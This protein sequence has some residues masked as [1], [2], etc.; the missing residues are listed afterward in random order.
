MGCS[1]FLV[2]D[3]TTPAIGEGDLLAIC[4]GSGETKSM[5]VYADTAIKC[6][7]K[8]LLFTTKDSSSLAEKADSIVVIHGKAAKNKEDGKQLSAQPLSNLFAQA[9]GLTMDMLVI[10][11]MNKRNIDEDHMKAYH[12]NLE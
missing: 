6:G 12:A 11:L 8:V 4:S 7:A 1:A 5:M 3:V 9:L 10:E 2:G